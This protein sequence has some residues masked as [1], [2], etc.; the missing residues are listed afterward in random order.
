MTRNDFVAIPETA[1]QHLFAHMS[2]EAM[3]RLLRMYVIDVDGSPNPDGIRAMCIAHSAN[4]YD[5]LCEAGEDAADIFMNLV[6]LY[7]H[8]DI[9]GAYLYLCTVY[10]RI[11]ESI[12]EP[13]QWIAA[14]RSAL[15]T[16]LEMLLD[17]LCG[18]LIED[19]LIE[20]EDEDDE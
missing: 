9:A 1:I 18:Y 12:P 11:G 16:F 19:G 15:F 10:A 17:F 4:L 3:I 5:N 20:E 8:E 14:H 2:H 13:I 7:C 6:D